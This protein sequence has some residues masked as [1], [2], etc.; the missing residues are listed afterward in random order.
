MRT[1]LLFAAAALWCGALAAQDPGQLRL[2]AGAPQPAGVPARE[3]LR[4]LQLD[5]GAA[6]AATQPFGEALAQRLSPHSLGSLS[7]RPTGTIVVDFD[8]MPLGRLPTGMTIAQTGGGTMCVWT[9]AA[10]PTSRGGGRVVTQTDRS[11]LSRRFPL[12]IW[13]G[14]SARDVAVQASF[15]TMTGETDRAA[16]LCVRYLDPDNYYCC[17]VNS[18]ED[19]YRFYKVIDG[20]RIELAGVDHVP[21]LEE[22]WQTIRLEAEGPH[23][24]LWLNGALAFETDDDTFREPGR[25]GFWTKG[26]SVTSMDDLTISAPARRRAI[27]F[28]EAASDDPLAGLRTLTASG[29]PATW[30]LT[31]AGGP[32]AVT[33]AAVPAGRDRRAGSVLFDEHLV[34]RDASVFTRFKVATEGPGMHLAG[35]V[36]RYRGDDDHYWLRVNPEE[37]NLRLYR[38]RGGE[39]RLLGER[40]HLRCD[41]RTWHTAQLTA[42]GA[43]LEVLLDGELQFVA[44]D[45]GPAEA[46]HIGLWA[47]PGGDTLYSEVA[48]DAFGETD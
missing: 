16:G 15:K 24:R 1:S 40:H 44:F 10:D 8:A 33:S 46:G 43:R 26:D 34:A 48:F 23:F 38:V 22:V 6:A 18:L 31:A 11:A 3:D 45:E 19:N 5:C 7:D 29:E 12:C 14:L 2:R 36:V 20:R 4:I 42:V 17:R 9:V 30:H 21:I 27:R 37:C 39:R 41:E 13:G 35:L 47:A 28:G 32:L 25:V